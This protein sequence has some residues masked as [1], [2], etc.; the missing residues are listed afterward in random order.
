MS[1]QLF[2]A[3]DDLKDGTPEFLADICNL[4]KSGEPFGIKFNLD[5]VFKLGLPFADLV[6]LFK[7]FGQPVFADLKMWN[8]SRTMGDIV[9]K[10]VALGV[11]FVNVWSFADKEM[12]KAVKAAEGSNTKILGLTVLSH[13][14]NEYCQK[15]FKRTLKEAIAEFSVFAI[16]TGCNGIIVPGSA[17]DVV[18]DLKTIKIATGVRPT[19]YKDDRHAQEATPAQVVKRGADFAVCGSPILKQPTKEEKVAALRRVLEEMRPP[20]A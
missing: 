7:G 5:A 3:F 11:D 17:L 12:A 1:T 19:W 15:W 9:K 6:A 20:A 18:K 4:S 8:G 2:V 14:D 16:E 10:L 13:Y